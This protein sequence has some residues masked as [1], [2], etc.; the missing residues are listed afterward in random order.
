[1][2]II[3]LFILI[4]LQ[5][6]LCINAQEFSTS[7]DT[8]S[9]TKSNGEKLANNYALSVERT[10]NGFYEFKISDSDNQEESFKLKPLNLDLF[11]NKFTASLS[12]LINTSEGEDIKPNKIYSEMGNTRI[13][14]LFAKIVSYFN[15]SNSRSK[16]ADIY[17]NSY[18]KVYKPYKN[19]KKCNYDSLVWT[20]DYLKNAKVE[21]SFYE[22][23]IEKIEVTGFYK[24]IKL[25]FA[26]KY[27]IG[28]SSNKNIK[29]LYNTLL[30]SDRALED[31]EIEST[32][33]IK[34]QIDIRL[35][36]LYN[37]Q[38]QNR[39][40]KI[41]DNKE[42]TQ[43][44]LIEQQIIELL[45][46][47]DE[48]SD[49]DSLGEGQ[50]GL[51]ESKQNQWIKNNS[52]QYFLVLNLGNVITYD[53]VTD[54]NA[55]DISPLPQMVLLDAEQPK[56][57]LYREESSR[58]FEATVYGDFLGVFDTNNPNGIIQTEID[59]RFFI[60]TKRSGTWLDGGFGYWGYLDAQLRF[61]KIEDNNKFL[62]AEEKVLSQ[63]SINYFTPISI[64]QH[65]SFLVGGMLNIFNLENQ[66]AKLNMFLNLGLQFGRSGIQ[67][68]E[69]EDK[70]LFLNTL[71]MPIEIK[72][73]MIPEKRYGLFASNQFVWYDIF[74][75][76]LTQIYSP[77]K[78]KLNPPSKWFNT[79]EIEA[80]L[81]TSY[82]GK[83]FAR[84]RFTFDGSNVNS[85]FSQFQ[86]GYSFYILKNNGV[87]PNSQAR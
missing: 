20:N 9:I 10:E 12:R 71:Q 48:I 68:P 18:I 74:S 69:D 81:N 1:M 57:E 41:I 56:A 24:N 52:S 31:R 67:D 73:H 4:L 30:Y 32:S 25:R 23:F 38:I 64:M 19:G 29:Q 43:D 39:Y 54:V 8:H 55:N 34:Q 15:S 14:L 49:L 70:H 16:S 2:K 63:D 7:I 3:I 5:V 86:F 75:D 33:Y 21:I 42:I 22:G 84:Y 65:Q 45:N 11:S 40:Q 62:I 51:L 83:L 27:S 79:T 28:L 37:A 78:Q 82:T 47:K 44:T 13:S 87:R 85:N 46:F 77:K 60:N 58:L 36:S 76:E 59:K 26:N 53:P 35:D 50:Y 66:N 72:V 80:Y 61:S 6:C 17:L